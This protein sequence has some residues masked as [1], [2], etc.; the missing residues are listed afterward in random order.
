[1]KLFSMTLQSSNDLYRK[2]VWVTGENAEAA[3]AKAQPK[4]VH[5][6]F[7]LRQMKLLADTAATK[8]KK[9][10]GGERV[11]PLIL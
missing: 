4:L 10:S 9:D 2:T 5:Q 3:L 7:D 6:N 8:L 11:H 1:M